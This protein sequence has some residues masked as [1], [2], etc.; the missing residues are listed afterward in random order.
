M[1][2]AAKKQLQRTPRDLADDIERVQQEISEFIDERV[3]ALRSGPD[4]ASQPPESLRQMLV[5]FEC[6]CRS[7]LRLINES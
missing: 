6:P 7:A 3:A 2:I 4:G 5:K 1:V